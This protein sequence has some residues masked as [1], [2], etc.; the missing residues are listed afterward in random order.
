VKAQLQTTRARVRA[1]PTAFAPTGLLQR[2]CTCGGSPGPTGECAGCQKER[3]SVQRKAEPTA[4]VSSVPPIVHE[5]LRSPG[6]PLDRETRTFMEP[7]FGHDF[8]RVHVHTDAPAGESARA[9]GASAYTMGSDLVFAEGKYSPSSAEGRRLIAHELTHVVQQRAGAKSAGQRSEEPAEHEAEA[10][11]RRIE[12]GGQ[13]DD[14]N[15]SRIKWVKIWMNSFI[16]NDI[17]D[18]TAKVPKGRFKGQTMIRAPLEWITDCFMTDNRGFSEELTA[19]ARTHSEL[20]VDLRDWPHYRYSTTNS[21]GKTYEIDCDDGDVE[22]EDQAS[23]LRM[24]IFPPLSSESTL[25]FPLRGAASDPCVRVAPDVDYEGLIQVDVKSGEVAFEGKVD[26]F[27]T[28]EMYAVA[29]A[30]AAKPVFQLSPEPGVSL[31]SL[32]GTANRKI[33]GSVKL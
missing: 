1:T 11:A 12:G 29:D 22:C 15:P 19:S 7:R 16:P 8:S 13:P 25:V 17:P 3:L 26:V 2:K 4:S 6:Q 31:W 30:G 20:M 32:Y 21:T 10:V 27:P 33:S 5:V 14:R 28:F 18:L 23:P 24:H 9:I